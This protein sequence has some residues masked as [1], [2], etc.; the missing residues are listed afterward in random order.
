MDEF[1]L[2]LTERCGARRVELGLG[3]GG[4]DLQKGDKHVVCVNMPQLEGESTERRGVMR[5]HGAVGCFA[6]I[7]L[8]C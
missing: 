1:K 8:L 7:H 3:Q 6:P 2:A 4:I 5:D